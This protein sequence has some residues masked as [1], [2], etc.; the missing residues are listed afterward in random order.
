MS[1]LPV[2]SLLY[3][4][5]GCAESTK[6]RTWL[7]RHGITFIER[8]VNADPKAAQELAATG[9]FATPLLVT[10][11]DRLLGFREQALAALLGDGDV[12]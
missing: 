10:G 7:T 1:E 3:T 9:A 2:V 8:N 12:S 5:V 11:D 4:Q 6:V